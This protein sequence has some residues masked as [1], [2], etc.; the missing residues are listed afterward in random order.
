MMRREFCIEP[1]AVAQGFDV[2]VGYLPLDSLTVNGRSVPCV[3]G[4][5]GR[6]ECSVRNNSSPANGIQSAL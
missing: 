1:S 6:D 5:A 3:S 4:L 2:A